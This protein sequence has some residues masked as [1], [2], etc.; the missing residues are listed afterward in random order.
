M[1]DKTSDAKREALRQKRRAKA[2][3]AK[4]RRQEARAALRE[5]LR[6]REIPVG[7]PDCP[8]VDV[9]R[10]V[11]FDTERAGFVEDDFIEIGAVRVDLAAGTVEEF[12]ALMEPRTRLNR[13]VAAMTGFTPEDLK[14]QER[15]RDVLPRFVRF[16]GD[17][18]AVGHAIGDNDLIQ[19]NLALAR[20][21][22][23]PAGSFAPV[24]IDT[25][26]ASH[27]LFDGPECPIQKFGLTAMLTHLGFPLEERHRALDDAAA[28]FVLLRYLFDLAHRPEANR[29]RGVLEERLR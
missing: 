28:S 2:M 23:A 7:A 19:I 9:T 26:H 20:Y 25:E 29:L 11:A 12:H 8:P 22:L 17:A 15:Q 13:H 16:V 10:I 6:Q 21:H 5:K 4:L 1:N 14:G 27:R 3:A 24:F 18:V